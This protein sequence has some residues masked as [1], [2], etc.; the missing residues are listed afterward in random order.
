MATLIAINGAPGSG[1]TTLMKWLEP[2]L[3]IPGIAKDDIKEF[4]FDRMGQ[5]DREWSRILGMASVEALYVVADRFLAAGESVII[6]NAFW[7]QFAVPKLSEVLAETGASF[8][9][10][11]CFTDEETRL[12]RF[13]QR[14]E[15]GQRH[16]GHV[17]SLATLSDATNYAMLEIG[18]VLRFDTTKPTE[19]GK[20]KLLRNLH[21][22][23]ELVLPE[24]E[25]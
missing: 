18:P 6:E 24:A 16:S 12:K 4:L 22:H 3:G 19:A 7:P 14:S 9:E 17:D 21:E 1:K 8:V 13:E 23:L 10:I 25:Q 2:E 15:S 20:K 11:Y 5:K